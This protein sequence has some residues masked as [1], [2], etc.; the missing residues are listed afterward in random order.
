MI[1]LALS[2]P[3]SLLDTAACVSRTA[4]AAETFLTDEYRKACALLA[5]D[6]EVRSLS[7]KG[8]TMQLTAVFVAFSIA[9]SAFYLVIPLC[10]RRRQTLGQRLNS[11]R[12]ADY[13]TLDPASKKQVVIRFLVFAVF[14][15]Y[16][17]AVLLFIIGGH[18][19]VC[20]AALV[21][22]NITFKYHRGIQDLLS[23]TIMVDARKEST[24]ESIW[25]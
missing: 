4:A 7:L 15:F 3:P 18:V 11:I 23:S 13:R 24:G 6:P 17:P 2:A 22:F 5:K 1:F 20:V 16:L 21:I 14:W 8:M 9:L 25:T 12:P 10:T 19:V